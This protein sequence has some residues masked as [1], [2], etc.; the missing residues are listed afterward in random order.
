MV[1]RRRIWLNRQPRLVEDLDHLLRCTPPAV[2]ARH[3]PAAGRRKHSRSGPFSKSTRFSSMC[4]TLDAPMSTASPCSRRIRLW[5]DSQR[6]ATS[7]SVSPCACAAAS[8]FASAAKYASF[9]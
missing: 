9:Q 6:S 1:V 7:A 5:C 3:G 4:F 2:S 8:I